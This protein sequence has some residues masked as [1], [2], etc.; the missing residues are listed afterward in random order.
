MELKV[1]PFGK[2]KGME[3][4]EIPTTYLAFAIESFNLPEDYT[5]TMR[6]EVFKRLKVEKAML[7]FEEE[8]RDKA[9][10]I[11]ENALYNEF[12][13]VYMD[14]AKYALELAI[15]QSFFQLHKLIDPKYGQE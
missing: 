15:D 12:L 1:F 3:I 14:N 13:K 11:Y 6:I 4:E 7:D 8:A 5:N 10:Q 9:I 2:Y